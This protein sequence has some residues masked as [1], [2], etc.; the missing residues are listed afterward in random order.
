MRTNLLLL[1]ALAAGCS[2]TP[3][4]EPTSSTAQAVTTNT[5]QIRVNGQSASVLL[6]G[7]DGTNG[8]LT[9][10][11]DQI[12][13]T[14]GLDFSWATPDPTDPDFADLYQGA[15]EIPNT[16]YAHTSTTASLSLTTPPPFVTHC[17]VNTVT[18]EFVCEE[19]APLSFNLSWTTNG[20]GSI[21]EKT[22]RTETLGP[23]TT[24]LKAEF[25]TV[26]AAVS[27]TYGGHTATGLNGDLTDSE[28][29]T[30]IR[31]ITTAF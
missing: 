12:N 9:V 15:G 24:K 17:R 11:E 6:V 3:I 8:F 5:T 21:Q 20:F 4:P 16:A 10:T 26:T 1:T 31:E 25:A 19:S 30:Y 27:G 14:T 7:S 22:Q 28:S 18:G 29:K 23:V 13:D 2:P